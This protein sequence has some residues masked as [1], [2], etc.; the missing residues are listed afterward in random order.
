MKSDC[1][2]KNS[3]RP[4]AD[5]SVKTLVSMKE[6]YQHEL[7][8]LPCSRSE[9]KFMLFFRIFSCFLVTGPYFA[10]DLPSSL[11]KQIQS[12]FFAD[13]NAQT[14]E[15]Y[16]NG[17]YSFYSLANVAMPFFNGNLRDKLGDRLMILS[18]SMFILIG[19]LI[20]CF[21]LIQANFP[22][23]YTGRIL[24]GTGCESIMPTMISF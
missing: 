7:K 20:F 10:F 9:H 21:G 19:Q 2:S 14:F 15:L 13:Q 23:M 8:Q 1:D 16:F 12:N 5:S 18:Q 4:K 3:N 24:F 6:F 11:H 17:L 22:T